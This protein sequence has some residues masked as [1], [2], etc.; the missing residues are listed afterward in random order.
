MKLWN[1][2]CSNGGKKALFYIYLEV[3][4]TERERHLPSIGSLCWWLQIRGWN[5]PN[6]AVSFRLPIW[7]TGAQ[8]LGPSSAASPRPLARNEIRNK[9]TVTWTDTHMGY[10]HHRLSLP[11]LNSNP[12]SPP[13][14]C[15]SSVNLHA[16]YDS[17]LRFFSC[18]AFCFIAHIPC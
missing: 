9:A 16:V 6:P 2:R 17:I 3:T 15:K 18:F 10:W 12:T 13:P 11:C 8:T 1:C 5:R 7:V 4:V 14:P